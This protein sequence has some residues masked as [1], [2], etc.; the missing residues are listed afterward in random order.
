MALTLEDHQNMLSGFEAGG[1]RC[2]QAPDRTTNPVKIEWHVHNELKK[3]R[4]WAFD[5]THGGGGPQVRSA[6]EFRIQITNGPSR[7]D[8]I[9]AEGYEDLLV[10]YSRDRNAIVAYD[11]RWLESWTRKRQATGAG[12]S[13]SV[14]VSESDLLSGKQLGTF[15]LTKRAAFGLADIVTMSP[16]MFPSYLLNH[17]AVLGG[18]VGAQ[19]ARNQTPMPKPENIFHYCLQ[20]GFA[21]SP[22]LIARYLSSLLTKPFVI[23]AGVSGTGKS[24]LAELTAEYY[25]TKKI[26]AGIPDTQDPALGDTYT[27]A[28][29]EQLE[30]DPEKFALVA[31]RPDW[32]DNQSILGFINPITEHFESTQALDLILRA[33]AARLEAEDS[34]EAPRHFMLLDEMNLARVEHYFSDWLACT[35]SRRL[36]PDKS[37]KQQPVPLHRSETTMFAKLR[38]GTDRTIKNVE[39]PASLDLPTNLVVTGT[40]N[41][42]ETT[43][44]FSPK[45]LDRAMV[46]EFDDVNL[47]NLQHLATSFD[48]DGYRFPDHLP[49]F[50]LATASDYSA[51]PAIVQ[52]HLQAINEILAN[53]R[54]HIG[55]R[56]A[57]EIALFMAI[58]REMLPEAT[59]ESDEDWLVPLDIAVLQ[60]ILPRLTGSRA[61]LEIPL[62][63]LCEYLQTFTTTSGDIENKEFDAT[64]SAVLPNSFRRTVEMLEGVRGFGYVS[65]FK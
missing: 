65:F 38:S 39:V 63:Q 3:Y 48:L 49:G 6:T 40:V 57:N 27:F 13:P 51:L 58:Y 30:T 56:S 14:Q 64:E 46:L 24:K 31:V 29:G 43:F 61:K 42:D 36:Q 5:I 15:R 28:T 37:I 33:S 9:D 62:A 26:N 32:I 35:E 21:F 16:E 41:V 45:V 8:E 47:A 1:F 12:G 53:A 60:K 2:V 19:E 17:K 22:D 44:G 52:Q 34:N 18:D 25:S 55:Y 50:N 4:L 59:V 10:G 11:R 7:Q 23:L 54:L 20:Q